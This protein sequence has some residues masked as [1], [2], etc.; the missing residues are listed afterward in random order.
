MHFENVPI[1]GDS[2]CLL[3][4]VPRFLADRFLAAHA[5]KC[6]F[7]R[8]CGALFLWFRPVCELSR[9]H[10]AHPLGDYARIGGSGTFHR[11]LVHLQIPGRV[12]PLDVGSSPTGD[13]HAVT[14]IVVFFVFPAC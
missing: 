12:V 1:K 7:D 5:G 8:E 6:F 2:Q 4:L 13:N 11:R 9:I 14:I 10:V 3:P